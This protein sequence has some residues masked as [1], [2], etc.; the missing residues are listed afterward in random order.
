M[1][2]TVLLIASVMAVGLVLAGCAKSEKESTETTASPTKPAV[3]I[4][5]SDAWARSSPAMANAGAIYMKIKNDGSADDKLLSAS[6]SPEVAAIVELHETVEAATPTMSPNGGN[7]GGGMSPRSI[8]RLASMSEE[9]KDDHGKTD[10]APSPTGT[11]EHSGGMMKMQ[12][13]NSIA[14]PAGKTTELKPGGYHIML[15][16]LAKPLKAGEEIKVTL[17]FDKAGKKEVKANVKE[18]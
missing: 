9:K 8:N 14:I 3:A 15:M 7:M 13:V 5:I 4:E 1:K 16:E 12:K 2:K 17:I 6:V 18:A 10:M 11:T